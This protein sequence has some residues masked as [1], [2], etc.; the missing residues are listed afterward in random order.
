MRSPASLPL[1][2]AVLLAAPVLGAAPALAAPAPAWTVNKAASKVAFVASMNGQPINGSF[3]RFDARIA[4]DPAN[5]PGSSVIAQIDTG[6]AMTGDASRDQSLPTPDWFN[7][8][9]FPVATFR[10]TQFKALGGNRYAATGTLS[11][12]GV[13]RPVTLPFQLAIAGK[14]ARMQGTLTIDRRWFGV[15]QGQFA[16]T[17]AVAANVRVAISITAQR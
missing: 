10:S 17:E 14:Q 6:S 7:T 16:G 3:R 4:F 2:A 13:S 11:I 15:G 12:R 8:K 1:L 5:L 9:A